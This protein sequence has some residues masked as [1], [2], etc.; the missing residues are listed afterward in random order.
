MR[1]FRDSASQAQNGFV[2]TANCFVG[3]GRTTYLGKN[4]NYFSELDSR[5]ASANGR[6]A[7]FN[8]RPPDGNPADHSKKSPHFWTTGSFGPQG[9]I[10]TVEVEFFGE[11]SISLSE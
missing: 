10:G 4:I 7:S 1:R 11:P 3:N 6:A 5:G 9:M 8:G 2:A